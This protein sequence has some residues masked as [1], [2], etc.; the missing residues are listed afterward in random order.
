MM[1]RMYCD[2]M[3]SHDDYYF[4][5]LTRITIAIQTSKPFDRKTVLTIVQIIY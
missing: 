1:H 5:V 4:P 3:T 2:M